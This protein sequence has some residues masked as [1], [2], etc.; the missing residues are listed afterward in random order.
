MVTQFMMQLKKICEICRW[1]GLGRNQS[2]LKFPPLII[3]VVITLLL[4]DHV[5]Y[6]HASSSNTAAVVPKGPLAGGKTCGHFV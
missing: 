3:L 6:D 1:L 5:V 2:T 4:K